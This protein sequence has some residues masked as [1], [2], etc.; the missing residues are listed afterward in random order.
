[1]PTLPAKAGSLTIS[2]FDSHLEPR[3]AACDLRDL[4]FIDAYGLVGT[5]SALWAGLGDS[6]DLDVHPPVNQAMGAHLT[7]MGLRDFLREHDLSTTLPDGRAA[8]ASDVVI[9]LRSARA[10]GGD[11]ALHRLL[12]EQLR[13]HVDPQVLEALSEGVWE[14]VANAFEH[15]GSDAHVMAQV[16]RVA[17]SACRCTLAITMIRLEAPDHAGSRDQAVVLAD[18]LPADL[19]G[20]TILLDCAELVVGTP[21]FLDE[22]VKQILV[23]RQAAVLEVSGAPDRARDLLER[24][25]ANRSV[26]QR[27]RVTAPAG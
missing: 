17:R 12:W 4:R 10:A 22:M 24:A 6:P 8:D 5:V 26:H 13:S 20:Q 18:V 16:Y 19:T 15:S 3:A 7:T 25:A 1:M 9:P 27:L 2:N 21:S 23:L 14:I 11:Q